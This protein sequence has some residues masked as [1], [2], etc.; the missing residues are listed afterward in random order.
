ML[1]INFL[2]LLGFSHLLIRL[3]GS[4]CRLL[5]RLLHSLLLCRLTHLAH[6][7][8]SGLR[9]TR[10]RWQ[11]ILSRHCRFRL[12]HHLVVDLQDLVGVMRGLRC[13]KIYQIHLE[14]LRGLFLDAH[15]LKDLEEGASCEVHMAVIEPGLNLCP[16]LV[17]LK[18][19]L[20]SVFL[21]D[22]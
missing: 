11:D 21:G 5:H 2:F 18:Y 13:L 8:I 16:L 19:Y 14:K 1:P 15:F 7:L 9:R 17:V 4:W 3:L 10:Q 6:L 22:H 20:Q 12:K